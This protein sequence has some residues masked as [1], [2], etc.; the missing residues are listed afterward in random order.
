MDLSRDSSKTWRL[1][2]KLNCEERKTPPSTKV[3]SNTIA[4]QL[5]MNGKPPGKIKKCKLERIPEEEVDHF[6][7][8]LTTKEVIEAIKI[9]KNRKAPGPDDLQVEQINK[10]GPR[11]LKWL[12]ELFRNI[13]E[14]KKLPSLWRKAHVVAIPKPGKNHDEPQNYRPISLLCHLCKIFERLI[15]NQIIDTIEE[16]LIPEQAGFRRGK[17]SAS[18]AANLVQHIE[19][20]FE[21]NK[22]TGAVFVDLSAAY[23]TVNHNQLIQKI[24]KTTKDY[25]FT[26]IIRSMLIGRRF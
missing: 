1:I 9:M 13:V 2:R 8:P 15:M 20:G 10:F 24:Y 19:N 12:T 11:T 26:E 7:S 6:E 14:T 5:V 21:L 3:T 23:D 25:C 18:Q 4:K 16:R 17:S 22:I